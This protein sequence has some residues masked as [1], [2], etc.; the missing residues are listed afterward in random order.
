MHHDKQFEMNNFILYLHP[1]VQRYFKI[2]SLNVGNYRRIL[3][4]TFSL[5]VDRYFIYLAWVVDDMI[6]S[7][8][9]DEICEAR[10]T[11]VGM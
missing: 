3:L 10:G 8:F 9:L 1:T 4:N 5:I 7:V 2:P 11:D 6:I